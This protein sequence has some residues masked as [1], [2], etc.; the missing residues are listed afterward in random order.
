VTEIRGV[1][2]SVGGICVCLC[3]PIGLHDKSVVFYLILVGF[4]TSN[5]SKFSGAGAQIPFGARFGASPPYQAPLYKISGSA[6]AYVA[7]YGVTYPYCLEL[8][9]TLLWLILN[10]NGIKIDIFT[11]F[12]N[13]A[14]GKKDTTGKWWKMCVKGYLVSRAKDKHWEDRA[15]WNR[16]A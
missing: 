15:W 5:F 7:N 3:D 1:F 12:S 9:K 10:I 6:P 4:E 16:C 13:M 14:A 2:G 11:S 8:R